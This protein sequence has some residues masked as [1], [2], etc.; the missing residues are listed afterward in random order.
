M[1]LEKA[2]THS[3]DWRIKEFKNHV[4][5]FFQSFEESILEPQISIEM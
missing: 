5:L 2:G 3:F 1:I 4:K